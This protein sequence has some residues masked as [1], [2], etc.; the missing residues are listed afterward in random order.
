MAETAK[1]IVRIAGLLVL[2]YLVVRVTAGIAF[3]TLFGRTYTKKDLIENYETRR[4][5][6]IYVKTFFASI[7]PRHKYVDIEFSG[8]RLL[9]R[10][11]VSSLDPATGN[12]IYPIF[13][14]W[15]IKTNSA[16]VD[17]ILATLHWTQNTLQQ[18]KQKLDRAHCISARSGEPCE[19]GFQRS[20]T[21]MYFY[22]LFTTPIPDTI[23]A[24][25]DDSCT[26][27]FYSPTVVLEYGGGAIGP[28][29][30][31]KEY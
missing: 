16:Q 15:N 9:G 27:I 23:K 24:K 26:Y 17:S 3:F 25:Y 28:Q 7:I 5:Q 1:W 10:L 18:L 14:Q 12:I 30:F 20:G 6:I 19:I 8:D 4:A 31:P 29:C 13:Q 22:N 11:T 2:L 21:G